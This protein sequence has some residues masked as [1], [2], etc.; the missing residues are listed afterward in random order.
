[1]TAF[2]RC[3]SKSSALLLPPPLSLSA[4]A[5][6]RRLAARAKP[7]PHSSLRSACLCCRVHPSSD[8]RRI[9]L[10]S[11]HSYSLNRHDQRRRRRH[12]HHPPSASLST[13][14][15]EGVGV[16]DSD[17]DDCDAD[18]DTDTDVNNN[19]NNAAICRRSVDR[20]SSIRNVGIFAHVDAGKTTVTERMLALSGVVRSPGS[21]DDGDTVT[22][23]LPAERE[24]G[25]TI[26]SAAVGFEWVV[27]PPPPPPTASSSA[28]AVAA[29]GTKEEEQRRRAR[30]GE[31]TRVSVNLIDTP[32]H[33]DFSVEVHRSVAVLDGAVLVVDAVAGVQAQTETV[34]RAMR[35]VD[36]AG[37]GGRHVRGDGGRPSSHYGSHA[38]EPLPALMFVNK[39]DR[40]GADYRRSIESVRR[41]LGGS[42]PIAVQLPLY[43]R[44]PLSGAA[45][46]SLSSRATGG[47]LGDDIVAGGGAG[48]DDHG[49]FV[50]VLD[51]VHMRAI[52]YPDGAE[53]LSME[54][55]VPSVVYLSNCRGREPLTRAASDGRRE[56]VSNLADVDEVMEDLYL[57]AMMIENNEE[58]EDGGG[59][60]ADCPILDGI[61]TEEIQSS[62]R[63][64]TLERRV[65]PTMC[66]AALRGVGVEP[67]LDCVAEYRECGRPFVLS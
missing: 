38:H 10:R 27:P 40:E 36:A 49:E 29:G 30:R 20:L 19:S 47:V 22:D 37:G 24:R 34:W 48:G 8:N 4:S 44:Q 59:G 55:A 21:V 66:G 28:A 7:S 6:A 56:L 16:D 54:D 18:A 51:L 23:Y 12:P 33:V 25:I 64:M 45:A 2:A 65:M 42:N 9:A 1:M 14:P 13:V 26:Q 53:S 50:G 15:V 11:W 17:S 57:H 46:S 3:L 32:G 61:S 63:R 35:N 39:M 31:P 41:K 58:E 67:L 43:R 52:L 62:L 5:S 60:G